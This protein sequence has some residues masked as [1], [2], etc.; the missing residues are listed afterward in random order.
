VY[1]DVETFLAENVLDILH[2][3]TPPESHRAI[4]TQAAERVPVIICEKPLA[5]NSSEAEAIA[6]IHRQ[7]KVKILTNHE[8]RYSR[9][10]RRVKERI[11]QKVYGRLLSVASRLYMGGRASVEDI[12]LNDGSHLV[13]IVHYLTDGRLQA[14][15]AT[16]V[17]EPGQ[18]TLFIGSRLGFAG[19]SPEQELPVSI[20]VG[21]GR[22]HVVFEL[23]LSFSR[24]RIRVGNGLYEEYRSRASPYYER[25]RSLIRTAARRP[26]KTGYFANMLQDAVRCVREADHVPISSAEDGCRALVFIDSVRELGIRL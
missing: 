25:M 16:R 15:Q 11:E 24:G 12:L 22:D 21:S 20:E 3:A 19:G 26:G 7:G 9:D 6:E 17:G 18:E 5:E 4:V 14:A 8:R 2:V 23:D 1:P 10:Y 13:D